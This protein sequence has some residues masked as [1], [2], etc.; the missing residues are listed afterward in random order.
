MAS[1]AAPPRPAARAHPLHPEDA[2]GRL[3]LGCRAPPRDESARERCI[4]EVDRYRFIEDPA[5]PRQRHCPT[6][7]AAILVQ[8]GGNLRMTAAETSRRNANPDAHGKASLGCSDN[9][10]RVPWHTS[11]SFVLSR[12]LPSPLRS[13]PLGVHEPSSSFRRRRGVPASNMAVV[14]E[15]ID[16]AIAACVALWHLGWV[17]RWPRDR[18]SI[19]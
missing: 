5:C 14:K 18:T 7:G 8:P 2:P 16:K 12:K 4:R 13:R 6:T 1:D 3:D 9:F 15:Q 10:A 17:S 19:H 11:S